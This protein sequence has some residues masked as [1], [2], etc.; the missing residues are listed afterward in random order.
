MKTFLYSLLSALSTSAQT[1]TLQFKS[2][3]THQPIPYLLLSI[4]NK[5][6]SADANGEI[7]LQGNKLVFQTSHVSFA[8]SSIELPATTKDTSLVIYL[9]E[10]EEL[11]ND[12]T[13]AASVKFGGGKFAVAGNAHR[14]SNYIIS[15]SANLKMGIF[16]M[17]EANAINKFLRSLQLRVQNAGDLRSENFPIELKIY[18]V[19]ENQMIG[20]EPLNK[21][22]LILLS[23][24]SKAVTEIMLKERIRIPEGGL[25]FSLELPPVFPDEDLKVSFYATRESEECSFY[26]SG[27]FSPKW[28][29]EVLQKGCRRDENGKARKIVYAVTY[30]E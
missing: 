23:G 12:V 15:L 24:D 20:A 29:Q 22:Q 13:V 8:D 14:K 3:T 11:L 6:R 1:T 28:P 7:M 2:S 4:S 18:G 30:F 25:F 26:L 27:N 9:R 19:D 10:K 21:K 17:P 16:Y 5:L